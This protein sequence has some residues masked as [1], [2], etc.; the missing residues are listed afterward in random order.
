MKSKSGSK[1]KPSGKSET[2]LV[3]YLSKKRERSESVA[4]WVED[5]IK[6]HMSDV[7]MWMESKGK[8]WNKRFEKFLKKHIP[9]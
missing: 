6:I 2:F 5:S 4:Q 3:K 1:A 8:E 7:E 9:Q